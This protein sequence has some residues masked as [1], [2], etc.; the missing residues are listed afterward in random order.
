MKIV[1]IGSFGGRTDEGA[2]SVC[3]TARAQLSRMHTV[4]CID[5]KDAIKPR[6]IFKVAGFRPDVIHYLTGPTLRSFVLLRILRSVV[7]PKPL[8][9]ASA[10]RPFF[11][12]WQRPLIRFFAPD[13]VFTQAERWERFLEREGIPTRFVP[14][15]VD[16][17]RFVPIDQQEKIAIRRKYGLPPDEPIILHVGHLKPNRGVEIL[18]DLQKAGW[19]TVL[20][21]S[22]AEAHDADLEQHL[23]ESGCRVIRQYVDDIHKV[24]ASTDCYLFTVRDCAP[25]E[26]PPSYNH[27]GVIDCPLSVLEAMSCN[28]PVVTTAVG[29]LPRMF[30][31]GHG[32]YYYDG[33]LP[34]A[35]EKITLALEASPCTRRLVE[36][37]TWERIA[38]A[39]TA[40]YDEYLRLPPGRRPS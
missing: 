11:S 34:D 7:W 27:V 23:L 10:T 6:S 37:L 21:A 39:W 26:L 13:L 3:Q 33:T 12:Y 4:L 17:R 22:T 9:V 25:H 32:F 36:E 30:G 5:T 19:C 35:I 2:R 18:A 31:K 24:I 28:V 38:D 40:T 14:N 1:L 16:T 8:V 29:A 20:V 15:G